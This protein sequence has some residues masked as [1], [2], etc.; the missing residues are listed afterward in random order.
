[1]GCGEFDAFFGRLDS[2]QRSESGETTSIQT[3]NVKVLFIDPCSRNATLE[4][5]IVF[6]SPKR[7]CS[8]YDFSEGLAFKLHSLKE[9]SKLLA[10]VR[11]VRFHDQRKSVS[12]R[13][14]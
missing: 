11:Q 8:A 6:I 7:V 9:Q 2:P 13:D 4:Y 1:M 5:F 12:F 3:P 10:I 14:F